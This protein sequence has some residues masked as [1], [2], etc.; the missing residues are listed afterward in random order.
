MVAKRSS[1][2]EERWVLMIDIHAHILPGVDDG[3]ES[4][5]TSIQ[6]AK[7]A[8][9]SGVH[10]LIV[11]PH[12]NKE[13]TFDNFYDEYFIE[14][15]QTLAKEIEQEN[16][17]LQVLP[18]MEVYATEEVPRLLHKGKLITLNHSRYLLM[19][20]GNYQ[21]LSLLEFLFQELSDLG[22]HPIIAHPERYP[23]VQQH[24][25]MVCDWLERGC[26]LQ[27]NKGSLFGSFGRKAR[28]TSFYLLNHDLVSCIAS[29]AHSQFRR[30][31]DMTE[32][33]EYIQNNYSKK[34]A[35]LLLEENPKCILENQELIK[36]IRP[37]GL[38][39]RRILL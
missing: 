28:N 22:L 10:T 26:Y 30:N 17:P 38:R 2:N 35:D 25:D 29:D 6:M 1:F 18:G 27:V 12:C 23:Y 37:D 16:I 21:D 5:Q 15:F 11:T 31:T 3:S 34:Y 32:T 7:M 19:E 24:P 39:K 8:A 36:T 9:E 20:F 33:Y 13:G 14:R 4:M